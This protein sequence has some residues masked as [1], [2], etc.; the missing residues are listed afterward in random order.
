MT[1]HRSSL[2]L[3]VAL[4]AALAPPAAGHDLWLEPSDFT[5]RPGAEVTV[6]VRVGDGYPGEALPWRP[7]ATVRFTVVGGSSERPIEP[8]DGT[9]AAGFVALEGDQA[10]VFRSGE[11]AIEL[12]AEQFESYLAEEGLDGVIARRA[13]RGESGRPGRELYSRSVKALLR[14]GG[15]GGGA[16]R[17]VHV[18]PTGL[19]LELVPSTSPYDLAAGGELEL[20]LLWKGEPLAGALVEAVRAE[21]PEKRY[22]RRSDE[23]GAVRFPLAASGLWRLA[24][25]HMQQADGPAA[26]W[27]SVWT[28]LTFRIDD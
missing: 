21:A 10:V 28:T 20:T 15:E 11:A 6:D 25:V 4:A 23:R 7:A 5:P 13:E 12:P 26:D 1:I 14:G 16:A 24:A 17:S 19:D 27:Q 8:R 2:S 18:R 9:P 3:A 22:S